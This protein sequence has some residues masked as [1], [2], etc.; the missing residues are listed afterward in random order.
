MGITKR[1][2]LFVLFGVAVAANGGSA[3][4][5]VTRKKNRLTIDPDGSELVYRDG[6]IE[7]VK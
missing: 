7:A 3:I 5:Y 6:W 4:L 2:F 1:G